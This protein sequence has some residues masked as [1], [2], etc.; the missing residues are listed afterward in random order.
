MRKCYICGLEKPLTE[1]YTNKAKYGGYAYECKLCSKIRATYY[2]QAHSEER[3]EYQEQYRLAHLEELRI[4]S[5]EKYL[6]TREIVIER[7]RL[8]ALDNPEKAKALKVISAHRRRT[9][10]INAPINDLT[11]AQ[12]QEILF[13]YNFR[14]VYCPPD[15]WRCKQHKHK[16]TQDHI[17]PVLKGGSYTVSNIVPACDTCNKKKAAGP[18]PV[19]IQP[20][21]LTIE[22]PK[23]STKY[24]L[25]L[26]KKKQP[27][28]C[29]AQN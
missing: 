7:S 15:C 12:W 22:P 3:R 17:T 25:R 16:L 21:L 2:A 11:D 10:Q 9:R 14:C 6:R 20:L 23:P 24:A 5:H 1:F 29:K 13:A 26:L 28:V 19:P 18:V 4:K 27:G 8:W